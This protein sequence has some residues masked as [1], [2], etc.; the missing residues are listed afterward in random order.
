M[1]KV[2]IQFISFLLLFFGMWWG[3][4]FIDWRGVLKVEETSQNIEKE[5]GSFVWESIEQSTTI[6]DKD[7][8]KLPIDSILQTLCNRN[9]IDTTTIKLYIIKEKEVNAFALPDGYLI[10]HTGLIEAVDSP[11]ELCGVMAHELAH[12]KLG[13][14]MDKLIK[15]VGMATLAGIVSGNKN[16]SQIV[17]LLSSTAF[18]RKAEKEADIQAIR[19]LLKAGVEAEALASFMSKI[20]T[21]NTKE[22]AEYWEWFSTHP[23]AASRATYIIEEAKKLKSADFKQTP[24]LHPATWEKMKAVL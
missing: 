10:L 21:E 11:E 20:S 14:Y 12:I 8:I 15:E 24:L 6:V 17:H 16:L 22:D 5:L 2:I 4:S 7:E 1:K 13:H 3:L 9:E 23:N 18:S 19:Y